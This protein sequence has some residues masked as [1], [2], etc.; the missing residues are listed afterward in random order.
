MASPELQAILAFAADNPLPPFPTDVAQWRVENDALLS[1]PL[2]DGTVEEAG[3]L[4]GRPALW[5]RPATRATTR[6]NRTVLFLHGGAY[7]VGSIAAYRPFASRL[8]LVLD[9]TMVVLDYRLAPEHRFPA[10]V[11]DVLAAYRE[12]LARG[13]DPGALAVLGDS[14]GG[15]LTCCLLVA[16]AREA[17]AQPAAAAAISPWLDL[18]LAGDSYADEGRDP[19]LR[20]DA[21]RRSAAAYLGGADPRSPLASPVFADDAQLGAL[22]PLLLQ[23][24]TRELLMDDSVTL[25]ARIDAAGGDAVLEVWDDCPHVWHMM[26]DG[27]PEA[28]DAMVHLR[29]FLDE[30][31]T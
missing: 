23:V 15:G 16:A 28:R 24:G 6:P 11:D 3:T 27:V 1:G 7:E 20:R 2:A 10:A 4:G 13:S 5:V 31:W 29:D 19:F 25:A 18:S 22:A 12:L 30:H 21:L 14:A 9:A 26:G 8:A 17:V